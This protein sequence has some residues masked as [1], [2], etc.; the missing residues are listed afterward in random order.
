MPAR[1]HLRAFSL[2][3]V[4]AAGLASMLA[5]LFSLPQ[6]GIEGVGIWTELVK[7][8]S[9]SETG[10]FVPAPAFSDA[11]HAGS[12]QVSHCGWVALGESRFVYRQHAQHLRQIVR[13]V[14]FFRGEAAKVA[15]RNA[16]VLCDVHSLVLAALPQFVADAMKGAVFFNPSRNGSQ[17]EF[18]RW[19]PCVSRF[20]LEHDGL[21]SER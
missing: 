17:H 7:I 14:R 16:Q 13:C 12:P 9:G 11:E 1:I 2:H 3:G 18:N 4:N 6:Q 10:E 15:E 20:K 19:V 21:R 5:S 8:L